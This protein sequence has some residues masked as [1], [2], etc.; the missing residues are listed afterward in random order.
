MLSLEGYLTS[1]ELNRAIFKT[2]NE[3]DLKHQI[4]AI[5]N[6]RGADNIELLG[7]EVITGRNKNDR[8]IPWMSLASFGWTLFSDKRSGSGSGRYELTNST[9]SI[10]KEA[11]KIH[12]RHKEFRTT[13]DYVQYVS[14]CAAL[15]EDVR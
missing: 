10:V 1:D 12:R 3:D 11:S 4:D 6:C 14:R 15:P 13:E 2:R 5:A 9:R 8:I 7:E